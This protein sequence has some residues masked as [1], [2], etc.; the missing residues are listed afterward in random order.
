MIASD[1]NEDLKPQDVL[2]FCSRILWSDHPDKT[3]P[4]PD[5]DAVVYCNPRMPAVHPTTG[6]A[7]LIWGTVLRSPEDP[8]LIAFLDEISEVLRMY[9][10]KTWHVPFPRAELG[11]GDTRSF[12][13]L[14]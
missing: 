11:A 5:I 13:S 8:A 7:T 3:V 1:G 2:L 12:D 14:E 10:E 4:F 9:M 6:Q